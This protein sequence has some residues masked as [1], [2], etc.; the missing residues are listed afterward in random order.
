[1]KTSSYFD[2]AHVVRTSVALFGSI[3]AVG[4]VPSA[5]AQSVPPAAAQPLPDSEGA[6]AEPPPAP[7][8]PPSG[9]A[10]VSSA[11]D[12]A[13]SS[14]VASAARP[15]SGSPPPVLAQAPAGSSSGGSSSGASSLGASSSAGSS[16][17]AGAPPASSPAAVA[18]AGPPGSPG[19]SP[20][21][22]RDAGSRPRSYLVLGIRYNGVADGGLRQQVATFI[23]QGY[24]SAR[25]PALRA[26]EQELYCL[27][28][29]C[30]QALVDQLGHYDFALR[31]ELTS[32]PGRPGQT[33]VRLLIYNNNAVVAGELRDTVSADCSPT[34]TDRR[35]CFGAVSELLR[36]HIFHAPPRTYLSF[37]RGLAQGIGLGTAASGLIAGAAVSYLGNQTYPNPGGGRSV[38]F[39]AGALTGY[40]AAGF[41]FMGLGLATLAASSLYGVW[42]APF[43][44][45][46]PAVR[47]RHI[48][49]LLMG[50]AG[51]MFAASLVG[52]I[53]SHAQSQTCIANTPSQPA[54]QLPAITGVAWGM[55]AVWGVSLAVSGIAL[56]HM[57]ANQGN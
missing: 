36:K 14:V 43:R 24:G 53:G 42:H 39:D 17:G 1:M 32:Q 38:T 55:T 35:A 54:C 20:P 48:L 25:I 16:S 26:T 50:T 57:S 13:A 28:L 9:S 37:E 12:P 49:G 52:A 21:P 45:A 51:S 6:V 46:P 2:I 30:F 19:A 33:Q 4:G 34:A 29:G 22:G 3:L 44:A 47:N 18:K 23:G 15:A 10:S 8:L 27:D 56:H 41:T 7:L 5:R 11:E 31:G 40:Q